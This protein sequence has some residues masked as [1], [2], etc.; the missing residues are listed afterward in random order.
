MFVQVVHEVVDRDAWNNLTSKWEGPP[1]GFTLHTSVTTQDGSRAFCLWE[2]ESVE[3]LSTIL[4]AQTKGILKN[5]YY[6]IDQK[7]PLTVLPREAV[8]R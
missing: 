3:A 2:V 4:D 8:S 1:L 6:A 7:A 5:T